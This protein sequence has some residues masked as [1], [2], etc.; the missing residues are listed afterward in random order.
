MLWVI[1]PGEGDLVGSE[2]AFNRLAIDLLWPGPAFWRTEHDHWPDSRL[3]VR[4]SRSIVPRLFLNRLDIVEHPVQDSGHLLVHARRIV[5]RHE[6]RRI[7][8]ALEKLRELV[9]R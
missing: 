8:V 2:G 1:E 6:I 7:A 5:A 3:L 4:L 9:V